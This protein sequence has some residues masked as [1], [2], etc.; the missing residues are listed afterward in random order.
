MPHAKACPL[1]R[2]GLI[3]AGME[4]TPEGVIFHA[5][6]L[7]DGETVAETGSWPHAID[8]E[9]GAAVADAL[10]DTYGALF[11]GWCAHKAAGREAPAARRPAAA[12]QMHTPCPA[13]WAGR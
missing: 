10:T 2:S 12:P 3:T 11:D 9:D 7:F 8:P 6:L 4:A 13:L 5:P 1:V